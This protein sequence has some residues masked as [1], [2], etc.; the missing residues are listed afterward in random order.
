MA[1]QS[2]VFTTYTQELQNRLNKVLTDINEAER[3]LV[4]VKINPIQSEE[5]IDGTMLLVTVISK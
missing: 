5:N 1:Y 4:D 3:E 2:K